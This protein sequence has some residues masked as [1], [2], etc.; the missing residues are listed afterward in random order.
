MQ[1]DALLST[2]QVAE[3][4]G[5]DVATI[6]RYVRLGRLTPSMQFPGVKGARMLHPAEVERFA[7]ATG[8]AS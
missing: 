4:L 6:N 3:R 2:A 5:K 7:A 1:N 8:V